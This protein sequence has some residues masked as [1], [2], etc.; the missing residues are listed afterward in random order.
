MTDHAEH[1]E[2]HVPTLTAVLSTDGTTVVALTENE[3][4]HRL[5]ISDGTSG[6]DNG[7]TNAKHDSNDVPT[8]MAVSSADGVTPVVLYTDANGKILVQT[9]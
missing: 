2:N 7:P 4:N 6:S 5:K 1:D 8:I 9:T 3:T